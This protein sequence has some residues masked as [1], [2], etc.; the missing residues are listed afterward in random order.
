MFDQIIESI[1]VAL[2][3]NFLLCYVTDEGDRQPG[4]ARGAARA[5]H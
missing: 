2:F 1:K 4:G 3:C 5:V